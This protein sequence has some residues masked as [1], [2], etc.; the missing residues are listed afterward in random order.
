MRSS[1]LLTMAERVGAVFTKEERE[2]FYH[3]GEMKFVS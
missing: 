2:V 1:H 3:T